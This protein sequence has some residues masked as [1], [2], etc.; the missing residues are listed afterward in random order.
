MTSMF[1][2]KISNKDKSYIYLKKC[3]YELI[4]LFHKSHKSWCLHGSIFILRASIKHSQFIGPLR[5]CRRINYTT[6]KHYIDINVTGISGYCFEV[7]K[8][9][10]SLYLLISPCCRSPVSTRCKGALSR[11]SA[12]SMKSLVSL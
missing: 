5:V 1:T 10:L 2:P 6:E 9:F 8:W 11:S 3:K 12:S 7:L 4:K